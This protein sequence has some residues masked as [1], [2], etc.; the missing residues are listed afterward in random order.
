[1]ASRSRIGR[2]AGLVIDFA[3]PAI[4]FYLGL[5]AVLAHGGIGGALVLAFVTF[6]LL[7][8]GARWLWRN[9]G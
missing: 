5:P 9:Y 1:M 6:Y 3:V 4:L 7:P 8:T 2:F